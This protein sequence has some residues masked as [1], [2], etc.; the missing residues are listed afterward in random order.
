MGHMKNKPFIFTL[1]SILCFIEPAIKVLYF[2]AIT[3]FDFLVIF[4]NLKARNTFMEVF[5]F[6]LVFPLAGM[7][8]FK[9]RRWTYFAFMSVLGYVIYNIAT[10]EKYTWPYNSDTPFM[11]NYV[12]AGLSLVVF[13]Y[14]LFPQARKPFFDRR[15]RWWEP[16]TR[17]NV[18]FA[19]KL[20][21]RTLTFNSQILNISETGAFLQ[22]SPYMK[23]GDQLGMEFNFL[24]QLITLPVEIVHRSASNGHAGFGV[25]FNFRT[26]SQSI[27]VMR[28]IRVIRNSHAIFNNSKDLKIVA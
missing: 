19:C 12:V 13:T 11:Y 7:F 16:K 5:D 1:L 21:S 15:V 25:K 2:K 14:F 17:Y 20:H 26:F 27:R 9:L 24:G 18:S 28:V 22:D 23:V 6:W 4:A 3:N 8:I 10:Y